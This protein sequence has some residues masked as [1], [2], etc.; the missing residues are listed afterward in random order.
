MRLPDVNVL[1]HASNQSSPRRAAAALWLEEAADLGQGLALPWISLLGFLRIT[2][3]PGIFA[4][5]LPV[6]QALGLMDEWVSAP[7]ARLV[8]PGPRHAQLLRA[9]LLRVGTA[10]NLTTD[11]HLAAVAME[12]GA[13]VGTFDR[14]FRRFDGVRV[15]WLG[16]PSNTSRP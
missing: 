2:T 15:D 11:A 3:R 6:S 14:D 1:V 7:G 12:H 10:G 9:L 5:P 13:V 8:H 4:S 16:D